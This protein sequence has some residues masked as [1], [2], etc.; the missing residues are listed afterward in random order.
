MHQSLLNSFFLSYGKHYMPLHLNNTNVT[1]LF[2]MFFPEI[3]EYYGN[4][5]NLAFEVSLNSESEFAIDFI[6]DTGI[7]AGPEDTI[8]FQMDV[9]A[10]NSTNGP[11]LAAEF[12]NFFQMTLN[13]TMYNFV[14]YFS[15]PDFNI[16]STNITINNCNIGD[17]QYDT[18]FSSII[19]M[20]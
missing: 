15:I 9:Y 4:D 19:G 10:S 3:K 8:V 13:A 1:Q 14:F 17:R 16:H 18:L 2:L 20:I 5:V 11:A 6:S 7:V 12:Q